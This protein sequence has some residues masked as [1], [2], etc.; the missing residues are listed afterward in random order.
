MTTSTKKSSATNANKPPKS[1]AKSSTKTS[2]AQ[3]VDTYPAPAKS[4]RKK[5]GKSITADTAKVPAMDTQAAED[6]RNETLCPASDAAAISSALTPLR[7]KI[8]QVVRLLERDGGAS[9]TDLMAATGWQAH[10]VRG[11]LSTLKKKLGRP[12]QST[13]EA[14]GQ[15]VYRLARA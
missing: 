2:A 8:G 7:G 12:L 9:L 6:G 14:D 11:A 3:R 1:T 10:S 4:V 15:R 5:T 13:T